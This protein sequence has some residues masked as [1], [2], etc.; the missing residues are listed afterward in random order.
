MDYLLE[1]VKD[2]DLRWMLIWDWY[3]FILKLFGGG[4]DVVNGEDIS[5]VV[6]LVLK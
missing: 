4:G 6:V 3:D 2:F 5:M 1:L